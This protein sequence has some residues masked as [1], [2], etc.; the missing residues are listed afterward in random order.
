MPEIPNEIKLSNPEHDTEDKSYW[1]E[2]YGLQNEIKFCEIICPQINR[3][4]IINPEKEKDPLAP[5]LIVNGRLAEL[6]YQSTPFYS[7]SHYYGCDPQYT[8]TF[9]EKDYLNYKEKYPDLDI[10]FW[11]DYPHI[12]KVHKNKEVTIQ[13]LEGVYFINFRDLAKMIENNEVPLHSYLRRTEDLIGN[14]KRSYLL[15]IRKMEC[16]LMKS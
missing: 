7:S 16:L 12:K 3:S 8:V 1:V 13:K 10:F 9:N 6:K 4:A 15:D 2:K 5:D 14:A 11:V